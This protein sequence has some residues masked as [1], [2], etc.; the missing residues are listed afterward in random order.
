VSPDLGQVAKVAGGGLLAAGV[1][2]AG[3][4][5]GAVVERAVLARTL[6][7]SDA[8]DH[9]LGSLVGEVRQITAPDGAVLH[10]DIDEADGAVEPV[11]TMIFCH[12]YA[13]NL[14]SW[15]YQR[16][17]LRG[18]ARLVFYDQRSHGRSARADFDSHH[19]EQL[20]DDL[21]AVIAAVAPDGPLI[22]VGHSMGGMSI[23]AFADQHPDVFDA[24]VRG[25]AFIATTAGGLVDVNLG[26]PP[27][28]GRV[29]Q[30]VAP[31]AAASLAR[32][33]DAVERGRRG[34]SDLSLLLTRLYSFGSLAP[35][36]AGIFVAEMISRTPIDVLAEFL[37]A[38]HDHDE[39]AVLPK[40]QQVEVLVVVGSSD[41]LTPIPHSAEIVRHIPGAEFVVV[42]DGG[43]MV[44]IEHADV[45][46]AHL[47]ELLERVQR[48]VHAS[49]A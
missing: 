46:N 22:L 28:V 17:A 48:N 11:V 33:K 4:A 6:R 36:Q 21:A 26:L 44:N 24:R 9:D 32:R 38:L 45:V 39:R 23:M 30:R 27:L 12:G 25:V 42:P 1:L 18:Q 29:F 43:H 35:E 20:G 15:H 14:D 31:V 19:I 10:V 16:A 37:P 5:V 40:F 34:S 13:L 2:A 7:P 49:A 47:V 8:N 3:A 41:R